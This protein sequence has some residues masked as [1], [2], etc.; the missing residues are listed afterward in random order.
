MSETLA[1]N[2]AC[3]CFCVCV[4]D[5]LLYSHNRPTVNFKMPKTKWCSLLVPLYFPPYIIIHVS[6]FPSLTGRGLKRRWIC[7]GM[8]ECLQN[9]NSPNLKS[10]TTPSSSQVSTHMLAYTYSQHCPCLMLDSSILWWTS[11]H[12]CTYLLM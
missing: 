6:V 1:A 3:V 5:W 9:R 8:Q 2:C 11:E 10:P 12:V 7:S 4:C